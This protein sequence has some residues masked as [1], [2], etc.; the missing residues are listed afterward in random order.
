MSLGHIIPSGTIVPSAQHPIA[1]LSRAGSHC[2]PACDP[3][4]VTAGS[5]ST[6]E[7]SHRK[8]GARFEGGGPA[9][10]GTWRRPQVENEP[11][12]A[13][14]EVDAAIAIAEARLREL[15]G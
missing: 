15:D 14:K 11:V 5:P 3:S 1:P 9:R 13:H 2:S 6:T 4:T 10:E 7:L 8:P 12:C